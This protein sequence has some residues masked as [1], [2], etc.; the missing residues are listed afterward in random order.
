MH[1]ITKYKLFLESINEYDHRSYLD[2]K[3]WILNN[4]EKYQV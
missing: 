4:K 2:A 1:L 3:K